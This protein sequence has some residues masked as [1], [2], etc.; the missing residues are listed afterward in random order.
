MIKNTWPFSKIR[1]I[2]NPYSHRPQVTA[3]VI[4][5]PRSSQ[6]AADLLF[7]IQ[8]GFTFIWG[9][10]QFIRLL[11]SMQGVNISWFMS[12][13]AFLLLNLVLAMRAH[14][15]QPSRVTLQTIMS[16]AAWTAM[17][18]ADMGV[19]LWRGTHVWDGTDTVTAL[20]VG[21]GL[22]VILV[23]A[24][25]LDLGIVDP[26]VKGYLAVAFKAI[27]QLALAYKIFMVGGRGLSPVAVVT[28]HITIMARLGQLWYS[29][30]EAGWDRNRRG[31]ALSEL[32]NEGSWLVATVAWLIS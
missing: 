11:S 4:A 13:L 23:V 20:L 28:G 25:R 24:Y 22:V 2:F 29:I 19:M 10:S 9:G 12:W 1:E 21:A 6:L 3:K 8:I 7:L 5:V 14:R 17:V 30:K 15:N 18:V 26:M 16:Y 27:P 31:S 32:A